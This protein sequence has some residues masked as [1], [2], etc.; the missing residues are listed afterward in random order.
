MQRQEIDDGVFII[1]MFH[2]PDD[3]LNL[4]PLLHLVGGACGLTLEALIVML[5]L[6]CTGTVLFWR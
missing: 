2:D 5:R 6:L 4:L 3:S 1:A